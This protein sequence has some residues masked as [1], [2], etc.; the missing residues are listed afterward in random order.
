MLT[1][2]HIDRRVLYSFLLIATAMNAAVFLISWQ[3]IAAAKNDFPVFYSS[4]QMVHEGQGS[5]LYDFDVENIESL[6]TWQLTAFAV[7]HY[8]AEHIS[9][10]AM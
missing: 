8:F 6:A 3:A 4:A 10:R 7:E 5:R 9:L 1:Q 2:I